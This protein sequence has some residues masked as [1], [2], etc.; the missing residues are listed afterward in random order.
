MEILHP[1]R[2]RSR[3]GCF[4]KSLAT[5]IQPAPF[6]IQSGE[7]FLIVDRPDICG[8]R[9][10]DYGAVGTVGKGECQQIQRLLRSSNYLKHLARLTE[11]SITDAVQ[12]PIKQGFQV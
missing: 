6:I 11:V 1:P 3:C 7:N 12:Q 4:D 10:W 2:S 5:S 9:R 8:H